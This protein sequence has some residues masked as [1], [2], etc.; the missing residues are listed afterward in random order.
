MMEQEPVSP[1]LIV[2]ENGVQA[3]AK[4]KLVSNINSGSYGQV[5]L[6]EDCGTGEKVAIKLMERGCKITKYVERE[7]INAAKLLHPHIVQVA[8]RFSPA[9]RGPLSAHSCTADAWPYIRQ[10][11]SEGYCRASA[12]LVV[13]LWVL[14]V[15]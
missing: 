8:F 10:K 11:W 5:Q 14:F 3:R 13:W 12:S 6:A 4:Y 9:S 7:V 1:R 2:A 15:Q